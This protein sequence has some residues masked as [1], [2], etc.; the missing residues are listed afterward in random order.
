MV[1]GLQGG[2]AGAQGADTYLP[3]FNS[4]IIAQSK[5]F[6]AYGHAAGGLNAGVAEMTNR[7][8]LDIYLRPWRSMVAGAGLRS[9]MVSHQTVHDVPS[10]ANSWLINTLLRGEYGFGDGFTISDEMDLGCLASWGWDVADNISSAAAVA[11]HAGVDIDLQSGENNATMAYAWLL[12]ALEE[13]LISLEDL[14]TAAGHVLTM[15]FAAG[16]FDNPLTPEEGLSVLNSPA[17][18]E[19]ALE[20]ARQG[21]VLAMNTNATLPLTPKAGTRVALIGPMLSCN[22]TYSADGSAD[23]PA[24]RLV[25]RDPTPTACHAREAMV[26]AY[27][28]DDGVVEVQLLPEALSALLPP[29]VSITVTQGASVTTPSPELIPPAVAA[30]A[31]ADVAIVMIGDTQATCSEGTDRRSL[32]VPGGQLAL[33]QVIGGDAGRGCTIAGH[34]SSFVPCRLSPLRR[35]PL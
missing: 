35:R 14:R 23:V 29:G 4:S 15:K 31:A 32:D 13:G 2:P 3:S 11:L 30:A 22:F 27:A 34:S 1:L 12:T 24:S 16:L 28:L 9:A 20:A 8:L 5:H 33:L 19:L 10:H 21:I 26:G 17:H 7:S 18:R 25:L 6:A